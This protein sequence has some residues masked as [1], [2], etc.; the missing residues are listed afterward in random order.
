MHDEDRYK[1]KKAELAVD[2]DLGIH[3]ISNKNW[4]YSL[5]YDKQLLNDEVK[6]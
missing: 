5:S 6:T 2:M 4:F 3:L 1:N